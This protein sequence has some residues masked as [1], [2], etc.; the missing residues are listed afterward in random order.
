MNRESQIKE[1]AE[2]WEAL[3]DGRNAFIHTSGLWSFNQYGS[4]IAL[5]SQNELI[6]DGRSFDTQD[7]TH[8]LAI[9]RSVR[10][11]DW[12]ISEFHDIEGVRTWMV[13][14]FGLDKWEDDINPPRSTLSRIHATTL[15]I[16]EPK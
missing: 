5:L 10:G 4:Q 3:G 15:A 1:L 6:R 16:K 8:C 9:L 7:A 12:T 2:A 11:E 14:S 13:V